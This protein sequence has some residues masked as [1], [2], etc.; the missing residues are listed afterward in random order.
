MQRRE[1]TPTV[2]RM[3]D[4]VRQQVQLSGMWP[5][6][7][8]PDALERPTSVEAHVWAAHMR[9]IE[10]TFRPGYS[11]ILSHEEQRRASRFVY[12]EHRS[13][14]VAAHAILRILLGRYLGCAPRN[15]ELKQDLHGKPMCDRNC[16]LTFNL[17]HTDGAVVIAIA[18]SHDVGIDVERVRP[19]A[20]AGHL[21]E[22]YFSALER[23]RFLALPESERDDT[24]CRLWTRKEAYVKALGQGLSQQLDSFEV[25][26]DREERFRVTP[27]APGPWS[28]FHL[29]PWPGFVGALAVHGVIARLAGRIMRGPP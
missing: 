24:F 12:D 13:E 11:A 27:A 16:G 1:P 15:V 25:T 29:D 22:R 3:S 23:D 2:Q 8:V 4:S 18:A 19:I 28:F 17:S 14:Y 9:N 10:L 5:Q 26:L 6:V 21:V 20:D 7:A